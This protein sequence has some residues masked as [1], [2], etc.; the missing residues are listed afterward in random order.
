MSDNEE[1]REEVDEMIIKRRIRKYESFKKNEDRQTSVFQFSK[2][3][4]WPK[5]HSCLT[6]RKIHGTKNPL[7]VGHHVTTNY[8]VNATTFCFIHEK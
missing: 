3:S 4:E 7:L 1:A 5:K 2:L 8:Y 6:K